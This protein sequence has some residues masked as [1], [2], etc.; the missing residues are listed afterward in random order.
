MFCAG[1]LQLVLL[2]QDWLEENAI[3]I[4]RIFHFP[5]AGQKYEGI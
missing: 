4:P 5:V 1:L 3:G 2:T